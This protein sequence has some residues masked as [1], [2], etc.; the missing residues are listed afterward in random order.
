MKMKYKFCPEQY[1]EIKKRRQ[2]RDKQIDKRLQVLELRSKGKGLGETAD[3]TGFHHSRVSNLIRK[4]FEE[5][6]HAVSEKHYPGNRRNMSIEEEA[7]FLEQFRAKAEQGHM[8]DIHEIRDTYEKEAGHR[9][10]SFS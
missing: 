3:L 5:G 7:Q 6:L 10:L 1:E 9:I 8:L 2:N 4:Y